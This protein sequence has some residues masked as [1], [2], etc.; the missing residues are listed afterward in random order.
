MILVIF[1]ILLAI[2]A[3]ILYVSTGDNEGPP[4]A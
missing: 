4:T 3:I 1:F 2:P